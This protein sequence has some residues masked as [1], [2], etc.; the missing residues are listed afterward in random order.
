MS[1]A[2]H[3]TIDSKAIIGESGVGVEVGVAVGAWVGAIV[4]DGVITGAVVG[5]EDGTAVGDGD[6]AGDVMT[7]AGP[8]K[9][10]Y[11]VVLTL[12]SFCSV[13]LIAT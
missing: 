8:T 5:D 3:A 4:G 11:S 10:T 13:A 7:S 9:D 2:A 6:G 1:I 12:K